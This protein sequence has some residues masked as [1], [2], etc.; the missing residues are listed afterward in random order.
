MNVL[1]LST[2][3]LVLATTFPILGTIFPNLVHANPIAEIR[4]G[5]I[6][7]TLTDE[8]CVL[9]E[10]VTNLPF[11]ST[12][13]ENG[14]T[15]EGCAGGMMGAIVAWYSDKTVAFFPMS[16]FTRVQGT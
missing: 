6:I 5:G 12:W 9:K 1:K 4:E 3:V 15:V 13:T 7:V 2:F 16:A 11:R 8:P 10:F 14:K